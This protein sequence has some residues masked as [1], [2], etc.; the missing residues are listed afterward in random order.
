MYL[1]VY[2]A[3]RQCT[4]WCACTDGVQTTPEMQAASVITEVRWHSHGVS[5]INKLCPL[6]GEASYQQEANTIVSTWVTNA[7]TLNL[8]MANKAAKA[9]TKGQVTLIGLSSPQK[10]SMQ[11]FISLL[12]LKIKIDFYCHCQFLKNQKKKTLKIRICS[13]IYCTWNI[14]YLVTRFYHSIVWSVSLY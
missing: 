3:E 6:P 8:T 10:S 11:K 5:K 2:T 9:S 12:P 14:Y 1:G 7:A 4:T 13:L